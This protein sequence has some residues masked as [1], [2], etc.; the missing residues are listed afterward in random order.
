MR[1]YRGQ[2]AEVA[3][4][5]VERKPWRELRAYVDAKTAGEFDDWELDKLTRWVEEH[6]AYIA[7]PELPEG[8]QD[9]AGVEA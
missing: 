7:L 6:P 1:I 5:M 8:V 3:M 9:S 2:S 4:G